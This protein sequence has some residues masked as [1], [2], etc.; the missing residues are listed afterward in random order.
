[1]ES[2]MSFSVTADGGNFEWKGGGDSWF[3]TA[4]GL[5]AQ[6]R[7]LLSTS[8][9][10]MLRDILTFNQQSVED[11]RAGPTSRAYARR[12]FS[13][14]AFRAAAS[15]R[16]SRPDGR[17]DLVGARRR[18]AQLPGPKIS[19]RSSAIIGLLQHD[20][21]V[22]RTV[23]GGSRCYVEKADLGVSRPAAARLRS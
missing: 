22:W 5:F 3:E 2:G 8:Y 11:Y 19:W 13:T 16:L 14:A 20:R 23:R 21:P 1:V 10:W 12:L 17:C 9:L 18:H 7:N 15:D 6:P 4:K